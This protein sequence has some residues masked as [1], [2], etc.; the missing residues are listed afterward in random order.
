MRWGPLASARFDDRRAGGRHLAAQLVRMEWTDPVVLG[1]PRGG[2]PVAFE[3]ARA[4]GAPL[5]V[6]VARKIGA[7]FQPEFGVGAVTVDGPPIYDTASLAMLR[8]RA[9]DL[10]DVC[11][12]E[13]AEAR[14]RLELYRAGRRGV[15]LAGRDVLVV[16]DGLATGV[17]ARAALR[18]LR[19]ERPLRLV[20]TA[21]VC[22][23]DSASALRSEADL[24]LCAAEPVDFRAVGRWYQDFGQTTDEE[25]LDL[26][27]QANA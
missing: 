3:I 6:V 4:L 13:R 9:E 14:R 25:V 7:P 15:P 23:P 5:D 16:D 18:G 21:P 11:E 26:L 19:E 27:D 12:R 10:R 1:L 2:V 20:F 17:T 24:V 8:L 22:A